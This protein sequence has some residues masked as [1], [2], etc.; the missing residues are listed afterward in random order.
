MELVDIKEI[1]KSTRRTEWDRLIG[2]I[3]EGKA[4]R[5]K[6]YKEATVRQAIKKRKNRGFENLKVM[7]RHENDEEIIYIV[8]PP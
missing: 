7:V 8:N 1:P 6:G 2:R 5:L 3:P 4:M